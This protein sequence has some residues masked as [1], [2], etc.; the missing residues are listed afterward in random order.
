M[1]LRLCGA[2]ISRAG[3]CHSPLFGALKILGIRW[4]VQWT[5]VKIPL[6]GKLE[7]FELP[8]ELFERLFKT[9]A[10]SRNSD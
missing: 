4:I 1:R 8:R 6:I 10:R 3:P 9:L 2:R 5:S 7:L